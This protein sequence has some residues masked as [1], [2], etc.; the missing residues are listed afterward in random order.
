MTIGP[1]DRPLWTLDPPPQM[2][3]GLQ[4]YLRNLAIRLSRIAARCPD[5]QTASEILKIGDELAGKLEA[6]EKVFTAPERI[7]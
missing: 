6:L 4:S 3:F 5:A 1:S 7:E 2:K